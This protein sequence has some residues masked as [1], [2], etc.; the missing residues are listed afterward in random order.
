MA[1]AYTLTQLQEIVRYRADL[2]SGR[3]DSGTA[4][5]TLVDAT[6]KSLAALV[7]RHGGGQKLTYAVG[8]ALKGLD[9]ASTQ[10]MPVPYGLGDTSAGHGG[11]HDVS[12]G[13]VSY[14]QTRQSLDTSPRAAPPFRRL[15]RVDLLPNGWRDDDGSLAEFT[16][17]DF[18]AGAL[19]A[20]LASWS[21]EPV[22]LKP[23]TMSSFG[24]ANL[25][26][27]WSAAAP[28]TYRLVGGDGLLFDP[29]PASL[30]FVVVWYEG[31]PVY[32]DD[33]NTTT[34][35]L[36]PAWFDWVVATV[37]QKLTSRQADPGLWQMLR[38]ERAEAE[39]A[40]ASDAD[41]LDE[42]H[43]G[44]IRRV[45]DYGTRA[46]LTGDWEPTGWPRSTKVT[47]PGTRARS[48]RVCVSSSRH[49]AR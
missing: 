1:T 29:P 16:S 8:L 19:A 9:G 24:G 43:A 4:F 12:D 26:K 17:T 44:G 15:V 34:L 45:Y 7:S 38:D 32:Q 20:S 14:W 39:A 18:T 37:A 49:T 5:T 35:L 11:P 30:A 46:A 3:T 28:P 10:Y 40:I 22:E 31:T 6:V 13:G 21:G 23:S 2:P 36:E 42:N 25:P 47:R 27:S 48:S 33:N 41:D